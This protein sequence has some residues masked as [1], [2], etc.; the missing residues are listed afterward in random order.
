MSHESYTDSIIDSAIRREGRVRTAID[1]VRGIVR[2]HIAYDPAGPDPENQPLATTEAEW[3]DDPAGIAWIQ[4]LDADGT[5]LARGDLPPGKESET[6]THAEFMVT[7]GADAVA[8][9]TVQT[10]PPNV[11]GYDRA[12]MPTY[13]IGGVIADLQNFQR[14]LESEQ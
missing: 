12:P 4:L 11:F 2:S 6:F 3:S 5:A 13:Q 9:F 7:R 1:L 8:S 14:S 10:R